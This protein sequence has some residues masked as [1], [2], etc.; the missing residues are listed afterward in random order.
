MCTKKSTQASVQVTFQLRAWID[1]HELCISSFFS[2]YLRNQI[3][4]RINSQHNMTIHAGQTFFGLLDCLIA[5][6]M[7][8]LLSSMMLC[9]AAGKY[10]RSLCYCPRDSV[11]LVL[12]K[13]PRFCS[14]FLPC[15]SYSIFYTRI[16]C[17]FPVILFWWSIDLREATAAN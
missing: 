10:N 8:S 9:Q 3:V 1:R 2:L 4:K 14:V 5:E 15:T 16:R 12:Y 17:T 11:N 6:T 7:S 13:L